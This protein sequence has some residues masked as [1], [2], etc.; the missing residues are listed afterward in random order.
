M[1]EYVFR[2]IL[3]LICVFHTLCS[4]CENHCNTYRKLP[5]LMVKDTS[6]HVMLDMTISFSKGCPYYKPEKQYIFLFYESFLN[7]YR[8][9]VIYSDFTRYSTIRGG[10]FE[11]KKHIIIIEDSVLMNKF[12][13]KTNL[14]KNVF[15]N[16]DYVPILYEP[17]SL[18]F[19]YINHKFELKSKYCNCDN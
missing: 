15:Y 7:E 3:C 10:C 5:L 2:L 11:Y 4:C 1:K 17:T 9:N 19:V 6:I 12:F 14:Y 13:I 16:S 18:S 8:S